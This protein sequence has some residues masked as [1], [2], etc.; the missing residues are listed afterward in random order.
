MNKHSVALVLDE[1]GTLMELL[2]EERFR[3]RAY[4]SA[5]RAVD[6]L[7]ADIADLARRDALLTVPGIGPA[8]ARVIRELIDTGESKLHT[9]LR[10]RTPDGLLE[11]LSVPG[12]GAGRV[13]QLYAGLG[14]RSIEE[15]EH[16]A[17]AGR[18]AQLR[19]FGK[20]TQERILAGIEYVRGLT[21]RRRQPS[22][23]D[24]AARVIGWLDEHAEVVDVK[25]AGEL[26]R[27][28]ETVDGVDIVV[29]VADDDAGDLTDAFLAL[30][31]LSLAERR[32][33][34]GNAGLL[35]A[36]GHLADGLELR[37]HCAPPAA[38]PAAWI[39]LT[40]SSKHLARLR[41]LADE[42]GLRLD[43][44]GL[45][46]GDARVPAATEEAIY[47]ALGLGWIAPELRETGD[48]VDAWLAGDL[49]ALVDSAD[50]RGCFHCHTTFS[51]G[52]ATVAELGHAAIERGWR[53]LGIA[54]HSQYAGYASGLTAER[55]S[56]QH[57]AIDGWNERHGQR[58]WV[59]KGTEA[60]ILPDG[61]VDYAGEGSGVLERFDYVIASVHSSF[62]MSEAQMTDRV[63]RA[64]QNPYVTFLGHPT[65]RLLL[66]REGFGLDV[67]RVIEAA[68]A[69]GKGIEI[70]SNPHRLELDWR[71]WRRARELGVRA[72]INP[73]AHSIRELDNVHYGV[74]VARKG[75]LQA[76]D[77]VNAWE[78]EEVREY[79]Q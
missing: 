51:D 9:Q 23:L 6:K 73:D 21:G 37:V 17:R 41:T 28:L 76:A 65:G 74:G 68:A 35:G 67:E 43:A 79:F 71:Y 19:G 69:G 8:T 45:W 10:G 14:V 66:R 49:P 26:R 48:E 32:R 29:A 60:D 77:V 3:S 50:L 75:W 22:A 70:N 58:V 54:D 2:G 13:H 78:L 11:L 25:L 61:S 30:P 55:V 62:R 24:A 16:A 63:L 44:L 40:G 52:S 56:E 64:L 72:A 57:A 20:K 38:F 5:A 4:L 42:R 47:E 12:L 33:P 53:Y 59:F 27:R 34:D 18:V 39:S 15:L 7:E 36:R 31:I 46:R 1:I